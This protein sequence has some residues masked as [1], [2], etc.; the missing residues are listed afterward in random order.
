MSK[1]TFFVFVLIL[2]A[3][4]IAGGWYFI[5][6]TPS[7]TPTVEPLQPGKTDLFPFGQNPSTTTKPSK[8][9]TQPGSNTIIDLS[10]TNELPRL[11]ELSIAPTAGAAFAIASGTESVRYVDRSTGHIFESALGSAAQKE[12][13]NITIPQVNEALW[14]STSTVVLRYIKSDSTLQSFSATVSGQATG[15]KPAIEGVFLPANIRTIA[16][17]GGKMLYFDTGANSGRLI[18]ANIDGSKKTALLNSDFGEWALSWN[19]PKSAF[20]YTKPSGT[21]DGFGYILTLSSG[22]LA[23]ISSNVPGLEGTMSPQGDYVLISAAQDSGV[24]TAVYSV[25]KKTTAVLPID[26]LASKCAWSATEKSVVYCGVP[27]TV[28]AGTY[29]DDW[30]KGSVS[31]TDR[32][33]KIDVTTQQTDLMLD[34]GA[35]T[36]SDIDMTDLAIDPTDSY[37]IFINKKDLSLWSYKL[38]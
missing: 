8:P 22:T 23:N 31:F 28:P 32:L 14:N 4:L 36:L 33:W 16:V 29:P 9:A 15:T 27:A 10:G 34:P 30:Y 7:T 35:Q 12:I 1:K 5:F 26:T 37:I 19:N 24:A 3:I 2:V 21:T 25:A 17:L 38:K 11:R 20:L 6:G 13:S 18:Q